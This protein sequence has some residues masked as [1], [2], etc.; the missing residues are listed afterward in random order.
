[1]TAPTK[2]RWWTHSFSADGWVDDARRIVL[3]GWDA[4]TPGLIALSLRDM[5]EPLWLDRREAAQGVDR[6]VGDWMWPCSFHGA[7]HVAIR[8]LL[9]CRVIRVR[10]DDLGQFLA[11][12]EHLVPYGREDFAAEAAALLG[13]AS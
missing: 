12:T 1:M 6:P 7:P 8:P 2:P 3:L 10:E 4:A 9:D 5:P 11:V 13:G